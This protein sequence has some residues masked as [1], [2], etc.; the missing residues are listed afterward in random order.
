MSDP[1]NDNFVFSANHERLDWQLWAIVLVIL[2]GA[3]V[4]MAG[5]WRKLETFDP[6][7]DF[8]VPYQLSEDYWVLRRWGKAAVESFP[9][10]A[11]GDSV[12]WGQ[13][14]RPSDS[15]AGQLN[16]AAGRKIF[17]NF[18][19]DGLHPAALEGLLRYH[20]PLPPETKILL[21]FNISFIYKILN[22]H[23]NIRKHSS[24]KDIITYSL[25]N[26]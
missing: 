5:I 3:S 12:F 13:Y 22:S 11:V 6:A 10:L 19:V 26:N 9:A 20:L 23:I 25:Q 8:R 18:G 15:L 4:L 1:E 17:A 21:N 16:R 14:T 7:E 24:T 2:A